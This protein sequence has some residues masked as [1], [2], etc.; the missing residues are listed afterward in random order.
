[1][2][3]RL[4]MMVTLQ[5]FCGDCSLVTVTVPFDFLHFFLTP[6]W[7]LLPIFLLLLLLFFFFFFFSPSLFFLPF[8][9]FLCVF[10]LD[11]SL[12]PLLQSIHIEKS[13]NDFSAFFFFFLF[14]F[15]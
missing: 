6:S 12:Q 10:S 9:F 4:R 7:P 3:R 14:F 5:S 13:S 1:M 2:K 11:D 15:F 8:F